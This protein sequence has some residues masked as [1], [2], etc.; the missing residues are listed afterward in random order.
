MELIELC[1]TIANFKITRLKYKKYGQPPNILKDMPEDIPEDMLQLKNLT[2]EDVVVDVKDNI[3]YE[4]DSGGI[5]GAV[6][7]GEI[8]PPQDPTTI[9]EE[10]TKIQIINSPSMVPPTLSNVQSNNGR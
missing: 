8:V 1:Y 5:V 6:I 2:K 7:D 9:V 4:H 10:C 3:L